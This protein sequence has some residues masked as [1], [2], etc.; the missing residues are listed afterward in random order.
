M[1]IVDAGCGEKLEGH[2]T[3]RRDSRFDAPRLPRK[4]V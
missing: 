4:E 2:I 3:G 1:R